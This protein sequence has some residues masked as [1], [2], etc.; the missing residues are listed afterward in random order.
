MSTLTSAARWGRLRRQLRSA[1]LTRQ[2]ALKVAPVRGPA[3]A[4]GDSADDV[5]AGT[6]ES[7]E[8]AAGGPARWRTVY[9]ICLLMIVATVSW[10]QKTYF[11]G[12]ADPVVISKGLLSVVALALAWVSRRRCANPRPVGTRTIWFVLAYLAVSVFGAWAAGDLLASAV[13]AVR[14]AILTATV[15]LLMRTFPA[16]VVLRVLF[17]SMYVV[18]LVGALTGLSSLTKGRL[19]GGLPPLNPNEIALLLGPPAIGLLWLILTGRSRPLHGILLGLAMG[20][21]WFTG[22]RTALMALIVAMVVMVPNARKVKPFAAVLMTFAVTGVIYLAMATNL[23]T[24]FFARGG[25]SNITTLSSRTIAWTAA[26]TFPKDDWG[27]F[28]GAGIATKKIPVQGQYWDDQL[29]DSSWV[30]ALVQVGYVGIVIFIVW[31]ISAVVASARCSRELRMLLMPVLILLAI[32]STLE[33]GLLDS[34]PA[35][36]VFVAVSLLVDKTTRE[37]VDWPQDIDQPGAGSMSDNLVPGPAPA[38]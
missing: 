6:P 1:A 16:A 22:S 36:I 25:D 9:V 29:L 8:S 27:R 23:L 13:L 32:R 30:S 3:H 4:S 17:T 20:L 14:L 7:R 31:L 24:D 35:F 11:T 28:M 38:P 10:R 33:S 21:I 2:G 26:F 5:R 15:V 18:A 12:G 19:A 34:T 37:G